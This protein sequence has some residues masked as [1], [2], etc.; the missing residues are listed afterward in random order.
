MGQLAPHRGKLAQIKIPQKNLHGGIYKYINFYDHEFIF[1][2]R[3]FVWE[4]KYEKYSPK[5][6]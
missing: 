3:S 1:V 4:I 2:L 6:L 5:M